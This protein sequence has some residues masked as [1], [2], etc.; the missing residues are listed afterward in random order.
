MKASN[1]D[2]VVK[3]IHFKKLDKQA[4][5]LSQHILSPGLFLHLLMQFIRW[6]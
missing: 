2:E 3:S 4:N 1:I 6:F 5:L